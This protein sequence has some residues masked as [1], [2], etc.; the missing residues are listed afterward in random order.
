MA[1]RFGTDA[2]TGYPAPGMPI[3][4]R[5]IDNGDGSHRELVGLG[6]PPSLTLYAG[7][8]VATSSAAP[9]A[10]AQAIVEVL[11]QSDPENTVDLL[12]GSEGAQP[13]QLRPGDALT[14]PVAD[15]ATI[16]VK[17]SSGSATANYLA[18]GTA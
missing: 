15:L 13:I 18:R 7:T 2:A 1:D 9:L 4:K 14:L 16:Y 10:V 3:V 17:T 5:F 12:V 8:L 6:E 11:V